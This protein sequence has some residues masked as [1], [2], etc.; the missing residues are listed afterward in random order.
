MSPQNLNS[1]GIYQQNINTLDSMG[2]GHSRSP[3]QNHEIGGLSPIMSSENGS[4][5]RQI[6]PKTKK[7]T[8][9]RTESN[10]PR[11]IHYTEQNLGYR[12]IQNVYQERLEE[13]RQIQG[14]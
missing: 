12:A 10:S 6:V 3:I 8:F 5:P 13:T 9:E 2:S 4:V 7:R 11:N 1:L 14:K